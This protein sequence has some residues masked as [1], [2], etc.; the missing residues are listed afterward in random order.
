VCHAIARPSHVACLGG[1]AVLV[2][3]REAG[4]SVQQQRQAKARRTSIERGPP[5]VE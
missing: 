1:H 5:E 4:A 3:A 2:G